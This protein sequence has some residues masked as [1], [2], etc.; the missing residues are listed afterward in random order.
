[1]R[2]ITAIPSN[3]ITFKNVPISGLFFFKRTL[4]KKISARESCQYYN[5]KQIYF[6]SNEIVRFITKAH[7][8]IAIEIFDEKNA[9]TA[10]AASTI[11]LKIND[12]VEILSKSILGKI[13]SINKNNCLI[14]YK[15]NQTKSISF[16]EFPFSDLKKIVG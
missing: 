10:T 11:D 6:E 4:Y 2:K 12:S 7:E 3:K 13:A 15:N 9:T 1:M 16:D 8:N 5:T 14:Q